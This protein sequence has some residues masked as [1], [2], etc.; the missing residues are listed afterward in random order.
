MII[1][2]TYIPPLHRHPSMPIIIIGRVHS[3]ASAAA[4]AAAAAAA[5]C[6]SALTVYV[7]II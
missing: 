4:A 7:H 5:V 6:S 1:I 2:G 3:T